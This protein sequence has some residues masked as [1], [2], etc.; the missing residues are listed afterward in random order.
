MFALE[1]GGQCFSAG[2]AEDTYDQNLP[3]V[4]GMGREET[5]QDTFH[6]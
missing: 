3:T 6:K 2:D 4:L 5:G 1:N